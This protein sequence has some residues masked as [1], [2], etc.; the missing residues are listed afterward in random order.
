MCIR[1]SLD[2]A[3][4]G[5]NTIEREGISITHPSKFILVGT[6]NP[7]EG[8]LRPQL[9]DRLGL[10][11]DVKGIEDIE[12]RVKIIDVMEEFDSDN[13]AFYLKYADEQKKLLEKINIAKS[14]LPQVRLQ[15][16][17]KEL[18]AKI[19]V[20]FGIDGHRADILMSRCSKTIAALEGRKMVE[21]SDVERAAGFI[22]PH[23]VR[24]D[25]FDLSL[26]H[27]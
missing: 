11:V 16:D 23:R 12:Q 10:Y 4:M 1:D 13:N 2:S 14:V 15:R 5:F 22:I 19:C 6:M 18:I 8:E 7:E 9:T 17:L 25:P 24:R 20:D 3:A 26:I 27:I 21:K